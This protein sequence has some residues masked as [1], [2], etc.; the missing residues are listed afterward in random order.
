MKKLLICFLVIFPLS[1]FPN[2]LFDFVKIDKTNEIEYSESFDCVDFSD[3]ILKNSKYY[4]LQ[5][6][7]VGTILNQN[8]KIYLHMFIE[9]TYQNKVY[10]FEPQNDKF[11]I[12][13]EVGK[14]LC[15]DDN[16]CVADEILSI[17]YFTN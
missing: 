3:V 8:E 16:T 4:G 14:K 9:F 1:L 7:E 5:T 2:S 6:R 15:F 10:W 11:Y 13:S 12:P 17:H